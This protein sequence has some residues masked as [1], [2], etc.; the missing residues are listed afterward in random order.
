MKRILMVLAF[1]FVS[2]SP[3]KAQEWM[4]SLEIAKRLAMTQGKLLFVVWEDASYDPYPVLIAD[5]NGQAVV[6]DLFTNESITQVIWE[7]FVPV[8]IPESSYEPLFNEIKGKRSINYIDK[9]NDDSVKIMDVNGNVIDVSLTYY[10]YMDIAAY[11][12]AYALD[13]S[14]LSA[15]LEN[16]EAQKDFN[17]TYRLAAKYIDFAVLIKNDKVRSE[18]I[19]LSNYYLME[20]QDFIAMQPQEQQLEYE[21][22]VLLQ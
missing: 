8:I 12:K 16:Y 22:K 2:V 19:T 10:D 21:Q 11:I 9:F 18:F 7:Y 4:T 14:I 3:M 17:T 13:T 6:D 5:E 15:E 1:L 20:A